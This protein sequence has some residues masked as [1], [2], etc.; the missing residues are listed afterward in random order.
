MR[1]A[2]KAIVRGVLGAV[3]GGRFVHRLLSE[4]RQRRRLAQIGNARAIFDHHYATN[5][6]RCEESASGQG[7]TIQYTENIRKEI[8]RLVHTLGVRSVLDAPCGDFNWFRLVAFDPEIDYVG[9][10]IVEALVARNRS[11]W[12]KPNRRF[13]CLDIVHDSLPGADLWLCRDCLF[14]LSNDDV[15]LAFANFLRSDIRY[16]LTSTHADCDRNQDISTGAFRLLNLELPPFSLGSPVE[17]IDDWID[18]YPV[19]HLALWRREDLAGNERLQE[20]IRRA[21]GRRRPGPGL[22]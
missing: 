1:T 3:P 7:S 21:S 12:E 18:G 19:R 4:H 22:G 17:R 16:L 11:M 5:E 14:H 6:W 2:A 15:M 20:S 8:P 13:I 10:D 9:G